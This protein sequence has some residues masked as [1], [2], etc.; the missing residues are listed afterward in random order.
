M[1]EILVEAKK[2]I[3]HGSLAQIDAD[4]STKSKL[5]CGLIGWLGLISMVLQNLFDQPQLM[6]SFMDV[7][8]GTQL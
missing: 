5:D 2:E 4:K 7:L 3:H 1:G 6:L 8:S